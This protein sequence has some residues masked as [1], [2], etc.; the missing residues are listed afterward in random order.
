MSTAIVGNVTR[1]PKASAA[2]GGQ[3]ATPVSS[4]TGQTVVRTTFAV[5]VTRRWTNPWSGKPEES[6]SRI[7]VNCR[8]P[9]AENVIASV[10]KGDRVIVNGHM[11]EVT[12][13]N[14]HGVESS[15]LILMAHEV[16]LSLL[17]SKIYPPDD[18]EPDDDE[19]AA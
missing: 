13:T 16:G 5:I 14:Q 17:F 2:R 15:R 1:D 7:E 12:W 9:L 10:R 4:R 18:D 6:T 19:D 8:G 11:E 3:R